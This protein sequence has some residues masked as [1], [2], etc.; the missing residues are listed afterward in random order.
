MKYLHP[1]KKQFVTKEEYYK[2]IL[3]KNYPKKP[4]NKEIK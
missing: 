4:F 3:S 1:I 2:F